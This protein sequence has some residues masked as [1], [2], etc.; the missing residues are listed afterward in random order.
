M[1]ASR[2]ATSRSTSAWS[3]ATSAAVP[4]PRA[5]LEAR[6]IVRAT[7]VTSSTLAL[8]AGRTLA[9]SAGSGSPASRRSSAARV[10]ATP[11]RRPPQG[12]RPPPPRVR[13]TASLHDKPAPPAWPPGPGPARRPAS[14]LRGRPGAAG[15][16]RQDPDLVA[17]ADRGRQPVQ[18]AD[19]LAV[20][21]D[22]DVRAQR[23]AVVE[24]P[25]ADPG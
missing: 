1:P 6:R 4:A 7:R 23:A 14:A 13:P 20:D 21:E 17:L 12:G 15:D 3:G 24:H 18:V 11:P 8:A 5:A 19:A 2:A 10:P 22:V 9:S 25:L 16:G